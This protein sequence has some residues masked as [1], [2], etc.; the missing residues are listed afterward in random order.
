MVGKRER[1]P[2]NPMTQSTLNF[3]ANLGKLA[4]DVGCDRVIENEPHQWREAALAH[5]H[6]LALE[7]AS[8]TSDT[9]RQRILGSGM[10]HPKH[11]NSWGA[12]LAVAARRGWIQNTGH[13]VASEITENHARKIPVWESLLI[14][15]K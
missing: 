10:L 8:F 14:A 15:Q 12:L 9:V 13:Y 2:I 3:N 7:K 4:K 11:G 1:N 5:I 6:A